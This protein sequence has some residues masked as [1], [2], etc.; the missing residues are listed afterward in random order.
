M[1]LEILHLTF[2]LFRFIQR[3]EGT[4]IAPL[5]GRRVLLAGIQAILP[6]FQLANHIENGCRST[7]APLPR[8]V[9]RV[10]LRARVNYATRT[11]RAAVG[12]VQSGYTSRALSHEE[13][14]Y[15]S[16]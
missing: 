5:A 1:L 12:R 16:L 8:I 6:R 11:I 7:I 4:E 13:R 14:T 3:R 10:A 9:D 15:A 2:M